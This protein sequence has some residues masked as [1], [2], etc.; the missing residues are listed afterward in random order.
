MKRDRDRA[1][2]IIA[3]LLAGEDWRAAFPALSVLEPDA[4]RAVHDAGS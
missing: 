1:V 3:E 2:R 4:L